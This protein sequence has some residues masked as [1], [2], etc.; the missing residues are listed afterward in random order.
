MKKNTVFYFVRH[1]ES[2]KNLDD[3]TGGSGDILT[4]KGIIQIELL[5]ESV[6]KNIHQERVEIHAN[7]IVQVIQTA[8]KM[9]NIINM[10]YVID[11]DLRPAGMGIIDGLSRNKVHEL[12]P[13]I[14][15]RMEKWRNGE[16]EACDLNIEGMMEPIIF[17]DRMIKYILSLCDGT[18][19]I[20]VCSRSIMVW[21]YNYIHNSNPNPG[22]GYKHIGIEHCDMISFE[23]LVK[24][25][26]AVVLPEYTTK[27]LL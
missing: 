3:I 5:C 8:Q 15:I 22:G 21:A 2:K 16:L 7:N 26:K 25:N 23:F 20:I 14:S 24:D 19:K 13:D 9:S 17:W 11:M 12:Y 4:S 10:P 18:Q 6:L 27:R 1:A